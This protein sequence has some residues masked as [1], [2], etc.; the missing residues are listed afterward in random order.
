MF[1]TWLFFFG[2]GL[3]FWEIPIFIYGVS[4]LFLSSRYQISLFLMEWYFQVVHGLF[5][6]N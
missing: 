3:V 4:F 6:I 2:I 1:L 5:Y